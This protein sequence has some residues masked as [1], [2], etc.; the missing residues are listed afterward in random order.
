MNDRIFAKDVTV[1]H[2]DQVLT[3]VWGDGHETVFPLEGLRY[4]CPCAECQGGHENMGTP[5]DPAIFNQPA[6][7]SWGVEKIRP[8][9]NYAMQIFWSDG[10]N[11]GLYTWVRLRKMC[12]CNEC[13]SL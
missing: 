5:V 1:R 8:V 2:E 3:I 9:G 12:P 13:N 11:T 7:K 4:A 10:H 6:E